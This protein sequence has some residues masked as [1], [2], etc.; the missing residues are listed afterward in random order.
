MKADQ[1]AIPDTFEGIGYTKRRDGFPLE[2][3]RVPVPRPGP[4]QVLIQAAFS[5]LNPLD[6]KLA[7]L[8]FFGRTPPVILGFDLAGTVVAVGDQVTE[9]QVGDQVAAMAD[10]NGDGGWAVGGH[11]GYALAQ[12]L[13]TVKKPDSLPLSQ[14]AALPLCFLG[15]YLGL[16]DQVHEGDVV[17]IPGG[18]GGVGH[19]AVQIAR[20][21]LGAR[22][23]ISSGSTPASIERAR[24]SGAD[25][26]FDYKTEDVGA[27]IA[28]LTGG[29]GVDVVYDITYN[30]QSYVDTARM[31]REGG[32]WIVLGVGPGKT[33]R[34]EETKSPVAEILAGR[35]ARLINANML[36]YFLQPALLDNP[37]RSLLRSALRSAME[38]AADG[39]VV[40]HVDRIIECSVHAINA[41]LG[42]MKAGRARVG[43][44]VV[45]IDGSQGVR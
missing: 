43:K 38:W 31:V 14:A 11:G 33:S 27:E 17:Y 24:A 35:G 45:Q 26:V 21:V 3:I 1:N 41:G 28:K 19:L 18:G 36:R 29:R 2:A 30:E 42:A 39:K 15:A 40:P 7:D 34:A 16:H 44:I 25:Y 5:S 37:A 12:E 13:Y 20:R 4:E 23:V 8:N 6:Y 9:F 32:T 22:T 10:S